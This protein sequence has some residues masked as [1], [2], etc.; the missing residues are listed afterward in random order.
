VNDIEATKIITILQ[1]AF[2]HPVLT[3]DRFTLY[4]AKLKRLDFKAATLAVDALTDDLDYFPTVAQLKRAIESATP[5]VPALPP[6]KEADTPRHRIFRVFDVDADDYIDLPEPIPDT[7]P[8]YRQLMDQS[9]DN[10]R[11][12]GRRDR[13]R[14]KA[15]AA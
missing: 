6:G 2:P 9:R 8:R 5:M 3:E 14:Q 15:E 7:D 1:A 10:L 4:K 12:A 13:E 11:E